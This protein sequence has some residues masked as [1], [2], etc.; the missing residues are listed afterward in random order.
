MS[1]NTIDIRV[2]VTTIATSNSSSEN[3]LGALRACDEAA[4]LDKGLSVIRGRT[5]AA[6]PD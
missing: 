4:F 2:T 6:T 1:E 3:P 5:T